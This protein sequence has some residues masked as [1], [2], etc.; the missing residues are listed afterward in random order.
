MRQRHANVAALLILKITL[1]KE[2]LMNA[3]WDASADLQEANHINSTPWEE[4]STRGCW[5]II[6]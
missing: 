4:N 5:L 6:C 1:N 3:E 2:K